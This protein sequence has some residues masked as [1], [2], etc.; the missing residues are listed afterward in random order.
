MRSPRHTAVSR[1]LV[2]TASS[3]GA[4]T[5]RRDAAGCR[6][7]ASR[8]HFRPAHARDLS[9][10]RQPVHCL[11]GSRSTRGGSRG[12][13]NV[14]WVH[15]SQCFSPQHLRE[16]PCIS[17]VGLDPFSGLDRNQRRRN[18]R[19]VHS[20]LSELAL[21]TVPAWPLGILNAPDFTIEAGRSIGSRLAGIPRSPPFA[22]R[23]ELSG[24]FAGPQS[25]PSRPG[26]RSFCRTR[27]RTRD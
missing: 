2:S 8:P 21:Q 7:S 15:L 11:A 17:S 9:G 22:A 20:A 16:L 4:R 14:G 13:R 25:P 5:S 6:L 12:P 1:R 26:T 23:A 3:S 27:A 24:W 19:A 18:H 10:Q